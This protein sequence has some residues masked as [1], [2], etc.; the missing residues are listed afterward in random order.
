MKRFW[1]L[2]AF[3][4]IFIYSCGVRGNPEP[5]IRKKL[6]GGKITIQ[7]QGKNLVFR[8]SLPESF[9]DGEKIEYR[10]IKINLKWDRDKEKTIWTGKKP[11]KLL[12]IEIWDQLKGEKIRAIMEVKGRHLQKTKLKS[13][14]LSVVPTPLAPKNLKAEITED[15]VLITWKP[16]AK[17]WDGS[18]ANPLGFVVFRNGKLVTK[19]PIIFPKFLD[20]NVKSGVEYSY[21]VSAVVN[22]SRPFST[23]ELS[24]ELK[25]KFVDRTPPQPPA[26]I[27]VISSASDVFISWKTSESSDVIGYYIWRD[28]K[29]LNDTPINKTSYW[30][31][32]VPPGK[33]KYWI[34]A[35]DDAGNQ[36]KPSQMKEVIIK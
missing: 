24:K 6:S 12:K 14:V 22:L 35:V 28:G 2:P 9:D 25:V 10:K 13:N 29:S 34:T 31:K 26:E 21:R 23:G 15:G 3:L 19:I 17:N 7:Q 30:D 8:I 36:S 4:A 20:K 11:V 16:P 27:E 32:N 33:H 1:F 18:E 5:P